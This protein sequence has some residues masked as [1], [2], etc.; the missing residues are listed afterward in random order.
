MANGITITFSY[1]WSFFIA[2]VKVN[3]DKTVFNNMIIAIEICIL[4][5]PN[6]NTIK[7]NGLSIY[8]VIL[9]KNDIP[10]P[11]CIEYSNEPPFANLSHNSAKKT[12]YW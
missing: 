10:N 7:L 3:A 12:E 2:N 5:F 1:L 9:P 6:N 8:V 11:F 4:C